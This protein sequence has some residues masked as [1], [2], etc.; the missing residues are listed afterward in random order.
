MDRHTIEE[1]MKMVSIL[2][3][4][5]A[6]AA[7]EIGTKQNIRDTIEQQIMTECPHEAVTSVCHYSDVDGRRSVC[8]VYTCCRCTLKVELK[9][10]MAIVYPD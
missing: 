10:G 2:D 3:N 9:T 8:W 5:I 7:R 4:D 1:L 6:R